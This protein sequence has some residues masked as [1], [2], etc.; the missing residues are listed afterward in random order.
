MLPEG[1][2]VRNGEEGDADLATVLVHGTFNVNADSRRAFVQDRELWFVVEQP[3][4]LRD[5]TST[6]CYSPEGGKRR[7][8]PRSEYLFYNQIKLNE[9]EENYAQRCAA[10]RHR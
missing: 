6:T 5:Q 9:N 8:R 3:R 7:Q 1:A 4:H 2:T 10:F